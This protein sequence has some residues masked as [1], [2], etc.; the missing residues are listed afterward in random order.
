MTLSAELSPAP[1]GRLLTAMITPFDANGAVDLELAGRL[2]LH[3]VEELS[4]IHI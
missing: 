2:A 4:L 1:F 3:L